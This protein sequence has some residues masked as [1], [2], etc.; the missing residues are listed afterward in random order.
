LIN[1]SLGVSLDTIAIDQLHG[2][3]LGVMKEYVTTVFWDLLNNNAFAVDPLR[4][5]NERH[6]LGVHCLR[7][8]LLQWY[9]DRHKKEPDEPIYAMKALTV[10]MLGKR[11]KP[12]LRAK[13]AEMKFLLY[14]ATEMSER[15]KDNMPDGEAMHGA[16][17]ALVKYM[18]ICAENGRNL[19]KRAYQE[20]RCNACLVSCFQNK[21]KMQIWIIC[22]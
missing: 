10:K 12:S 15:H 5:L 11:T 2:L 4:T 13:A 7:H 20:L 6:V 16:G 1:E 18:T 8:E 14:F 9:E 22:K 17:Q 3:N 19:P 21:I